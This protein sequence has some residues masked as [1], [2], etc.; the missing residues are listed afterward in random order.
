MLN[1]PGVL[2]MTFPGEGAPVMA[3]EAG[4]GATVLPVV[5]GLGN[6]LAGELGIVLKKEH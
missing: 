3:R 6:M 4:E 1:V 5:D 2:S